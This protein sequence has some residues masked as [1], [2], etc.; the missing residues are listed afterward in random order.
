MATDTFDDEPIDVAGLARTGLRVRTEQQAAARNVKSRIESIDTQS[1]IIQASTIQQ[2]DDNAL[3]A[4]AANQLEVKNYENQLS[5]KNMFGT[6]SEVPNNAMSVLADSIMNK[7]N[8]LQASAENI[9]ERMGVGFFDN[10]I[11]YVKN[12][13]TVPTDIRIHN[14][15][16]DQLQLDE[17]VLN[18]LQSATASAVQTNNASK[19]ITTAEIG[20]AQ[21][22]VIKQ[23]ARALAADA[24]IQ[25]Q[26]HAT[27]LV[28]LSTN[29]LGQE[30]NQYIQLLG[31][32][33]EKKNLAIRMAQEGRAA[34]MFPIE[35][36]TKKRELMER[37]MQTED[38]TEFITQIGQAALIAGRT[39]PTLHEIQKMNPKTMDAYMDIIAGGALG[40]NTVMA[41]DTANNIN[42]AFSGSPGAKKT[43]DLVNSQ[44]EKIKSDPAFQ[45]NSTGL[46]PAELNIRLQAHVRQWYEREANNVT[47]GSLYEAPSLYTVANFQDVKATR[48]G[49]ELGKLVMEGNP[50]KLDIPT[51]P[52]Q[53]FDTAMDLVKKG[54]YKNIDQ[55]AADISKVFTSANVESSRLR[56]FE[57]TRIPEPTKYK[58]RVNIGDMFSD[59]A[60]TD[61]TNPTAIKNLMLR[62]L[63]M[64]QYQEYEQSTAGYLTR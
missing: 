26:M 13:F 51:N 48:L 23:K 19:Q 44:I 56:A 34:K 32:E 6:N 25:N 27:N 14:V 53:V 16:A 33:N 38:R 22:N 11:E 52:Q 42:G 1:K 10:P 37:V 35:F 24:D 28:N 36:E 64:Q 7:R 20:A 60:V 54:E 43:V 40:Y 21:A 46:K 2:G 57:R 30:Y 39:P 45:R 4:L 9:K 55:A 3:I 59:G 41:I 47:P 8:E 61:M 50:R 31:A 15:N 62:K 18:E 63:S 5:I 17:N 58:T 49:N 12:Q 29:L